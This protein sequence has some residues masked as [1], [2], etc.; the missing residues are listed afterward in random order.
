MK[1]TY[2]LV[3]ANVLAFSFGWMPALQEPGW[4]LLLYSLGHLTW[5]H[6][7][8]N[9]LGLLSFGAALE[10]EW[11]WW[12]TLVG[13]C[14]CVVAGGW[15]HLT[16]GPDSPVAGSS[17]GVLGLMAIYSAMYPDRR[18]TLLVVTM[19]AKWGGVALLAYTSLGIVTGV[20]PAIAH[21]VHHAGVLAGLCYWLHM[22]RERP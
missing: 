12:D 9:M 2:L 4:G 22:T 3:L 16:L 7:A 5:W 8:L 15:M 14:L 21:W 6:L 18:V 13:Y 11:G 10:R 19:R 17:G 20:L 1:V